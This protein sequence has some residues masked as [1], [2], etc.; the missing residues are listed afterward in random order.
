[1]AVEFS[2]KLKNRGARINIPRK[3]LEMR[4]ASTV[5]WKDSD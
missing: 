2:P 4:L 3:S 1:M 5:D